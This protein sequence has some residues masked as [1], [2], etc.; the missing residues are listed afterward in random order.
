MLLWSLFSSY[1]LCS[2]FQEVLNN[3]DH[4]PV[5]LLSNLVEGTYTF[6]LRVTDAKGESDVERTTVEV[7]PGESGFCAV[8]HLPAALWIHYTGIKICH[9]VQFRTV[10]IESLG[11]CG[12]VFLWFLRAGSHYFYYLWKSYLCLFPQC[13]SVVL[14]SN[15]KH[16]GKIAKNLLCAQAAK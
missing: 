6:H 11:G 10:N 8:P 9:L 13:H 2:A 15:Q 3:S 1:L 16:P 5:L 14:Y 4:H 7:K 12:C